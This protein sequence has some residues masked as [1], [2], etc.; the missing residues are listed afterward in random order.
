MYPGV[1]LTYLS[2]IM[3]KIE[4]LLIRLRIT[5]NFTS[6]LPLF[7][8]FAYFSIGG[9]LLLNFSEFKHSLN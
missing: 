4:Y 7:M 6:V 2:L 3:T 8:L 9:L 1:I 5:G